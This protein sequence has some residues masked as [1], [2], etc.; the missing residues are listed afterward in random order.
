MSDVDLPAPPDGT[1]PAGRALW[2]SILQSY[3]LVPHELVGLL[4][5]AV[6]VAD[7]IAQLEAIVDREGAMVEDVKRQM[8]VPHPGLVEARQQR[9]SLARLVVAMRLP[10]LETGQKP[11]RRGL[12]GAY[13]PRL[14]GGSGGAA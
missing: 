1:G 2:D 5:Q 6:K 3:E 10:D 4:A 9:I 8:T 12:R 7:R 13:R 14:V 11:Q